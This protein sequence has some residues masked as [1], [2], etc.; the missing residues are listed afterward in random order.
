MDKSSRLY[1]NVVELKE[2]FV[3]DKLLFVNGIDSLI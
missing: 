3:M 2:I 1:S